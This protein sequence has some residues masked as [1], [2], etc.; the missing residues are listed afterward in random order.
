M[1][2]F[3]RPC[4]R[5]LRIALQRTPKALWWACRG[6]YRASI[7]VSSVEDAAARKLRTLR[8][9]AHK[10]QRQARRWT[11]ARPYLHLAFFPLWGN[12]RAFPVTSAMPLSKRFWAGLALVTVA[13][14]PWVAASSQLQS[15]FV[16][17][18]EARAV[19][20]VGQIAFDQLKFALEF[21]PLLFA[22]LGWLLIAVTAAMAMLMHRLEVMVAHLDW[23]ARPR[24]GYRFHVVQI[25]SLAL[26]L[27]L[28]LQ[29]I[30][31]SLN[32]RS[33]AEPLF[34]QVFSSPWIWLPA[35]IWLAVRPLVAKNRDAVHRH[36]YGNAGRA[37]L[38]SLFSTLVCI[39]VLVLIQLSLR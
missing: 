11:D 27:G 38:A 31:W 22:A 20:E 3:D 21:S 36:L 10:R 4:P 25:S 17:I 2:S 34:L 35:G 30:A 8:A 5:Q 19:A 15:L 13:T 24:V 18:N 7:F 14:G 28:P 9:I 1:K 23:R 37:L 6:A 12:P 33:V 16:D 32:H 39:G 26:Y 29:V